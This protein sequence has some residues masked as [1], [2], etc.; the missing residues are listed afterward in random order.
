MTS[1]RK[2]HEVLIPIAFFHFILSLITYLIFGLLFNP[3]SVTYNW[4]IPNIMIVFTEVAIISIS[5]FLD[6]RYVTLFRKRECV[7][8]YKK[9][10]R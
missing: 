8:D 3:T 2:L 9:I 1:K 10:G 7:I 4:F 5:R 6:K